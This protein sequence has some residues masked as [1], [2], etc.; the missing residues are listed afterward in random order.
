MR[1]DERN[2]DTQSAAGRP[3]SLILYRFNFSKL[4]A[5]RGNAEFIS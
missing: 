1:D 2:G 3:H 4:E 5:H